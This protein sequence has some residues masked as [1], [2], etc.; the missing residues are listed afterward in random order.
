MAP[1]KVATLEWAPILYEGPFDEKVAR[2]LAEGNS[3]IPGA[4]HCAEG[5]VVRPVVERFDEQVG[6]V[7]L[8]IVSNRYLSK[9]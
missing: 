4:K 3:S 7:Q 6:R 8:K 5:V 9:E 2:E 1:S